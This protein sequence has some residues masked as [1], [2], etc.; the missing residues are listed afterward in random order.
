MYKIKDLEVIENNI[1]SCYIKES[2]VHGMGL[3]SLQKI[4]EGAVLT[5]L[6]GQYLHDEIIKNIEVDLEK[7]EYNY[8]PSQNSWLVRGFLTYYSAINHSK[9]YNV[10]ILYEPFRIVASR[11]IEKDEEIFL[12]YEFE[13]YPNYFIKKY[14]ISISYL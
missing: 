3:F 6:D 12:N 5:T 10:K 11:D 9:D 4:P 14:N 13:K 1:P 8:L 7:H 2:P